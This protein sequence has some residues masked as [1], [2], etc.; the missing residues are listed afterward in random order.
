MNHHT[1]PSTPYR[2]RRAFGEIWI[3]R[4]D[5]GRW[6]IAEPG[7][8]SYPTLEAASDAMGELMDAAGK[9]QASRSM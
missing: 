5:A 6:I 4:M 2:V 8:P 9:P 3:E 7:C 1:T